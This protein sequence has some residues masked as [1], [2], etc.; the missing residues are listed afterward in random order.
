[1]GWVNQWMGVGGKYKII[2]TTDKKTLSMVVYRL[3]IHTPLPCDRW[4]GGDANEID[5]PLTH[6][7]IP[8]RASRS[9][10]GME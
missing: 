2:G 6:A 9:L 1:M 8:Y 10:V 5:D 7:A 3:Y 4:V